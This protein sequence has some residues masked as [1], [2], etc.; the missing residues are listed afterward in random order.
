ML[1]RTFTY[2]PLRFKLLSLMI[3]RERIFA[4]PKEREIRIYD[5]HTHTRISVCV[6]LLN[7][8]ET[9]RSCAN[10]RHSNIISNPL[11]FCLDIDLT[12]FVDLLLSW[13]DFEKK[14]MM[15]LPREMEKLGLHQAGFLAQKRLARG[16]RLNYTEAVALIATQVCSVST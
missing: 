13:L 12:L 16:I 4:S 8:H 10:R 5:A 2:P 3:K 7:T 6:L 15:L 11:R 1:A 14:K 9:R